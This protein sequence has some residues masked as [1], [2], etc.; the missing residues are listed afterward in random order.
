MVSHIRTVIT[1]KKDTMAYVTLDDM[2]G[3][4]TVIVFSD[5]FKKSAKI[6]QS[7]DPILITGTVDADEDNIKIIAA[8]VTSLSEAIENPFNTIHF[9]MDSSSASFACLDSLK[10]LLKNHKGKLDGYI[11][12]RLNGQSETVIYLGKDLKLRP[13][14]ELKA[15]ADT[16][17]GPGS[18][19]FD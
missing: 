3:S 12:L 9:D 16:I 13:S 18:T 7:G 8:D 17:L 4:T 14:N 11:H 10:I 6:M 5:T 19:R 1:K 2:K 15:A